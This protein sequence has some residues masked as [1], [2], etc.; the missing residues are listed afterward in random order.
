MEPQNRSKTPICIGTFDNAGVPIAI[1]AHMNDWATITFQ[2]ISLNILLSRCLNLQPANVT[3]VY[4]K[5]SSSVR[6]ERNHKGF[7]GYLDRL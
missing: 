1:S 3:L 5:A 6:I 4:T 7:T 2:A